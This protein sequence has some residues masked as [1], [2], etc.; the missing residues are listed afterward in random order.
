MS[1]PRVL[2][3]AVHPSSFVRDDLALLS[4]RYHVT[5]LWF[6]GG[7]LVGA[8]AAQARALRQARADLVFGWFADYPMAQPVR[9]AARRGVPSVVALGGFD[10]VRLP[11]LGYGVYT[12]RWRAPLAR[13]VCRRATHLAPVAEAL[14]A[15]TNAFATWPVPTPQGV[16]VHV[17]RLTTPASV[18]PTGYDAAAWP[19]GAA[20]RRPSVLTV[21]HV[22]TERTYRLKGLDLLADAAACL[23]GVPFT[24]VGVEPAVARR[25]V[26]PNLTLRPPV[27]REQLAEAYAAASVYAQPSRSEGLPNA[28]CEAMLAGCVPV[29]SP[30]GAMPDVTAGL[31]ETV[32]RPAGDALADAITAALGTG[33]ER[34]QAAR[35]RIADDYSREKRRAGLFTLFDSLLDA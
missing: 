13:S 14:L 3:V 2:F 24:V 10:A 8:F 32:H 4:E 11:R 6:G 7:S 23:P 12:S 17:P 5:P 9:W 33:A 28:L 25:A 35:D 34:R 1:Q 19:P 26:P 30:V 22:A 27:P 15:S 18:I 29:V 20:A 31:G 16:R 21:A